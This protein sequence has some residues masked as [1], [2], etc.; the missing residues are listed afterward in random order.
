MRGS[1]ALTLRTELECVPLQP[2]SN[3]GDTFVLEQAGCHEYDHEIVGD[4]PKLKRVLEQVES[5]AP[6]DST[7]LILGETGTGKELVARRIHNRSARRQ[8]AFVI[9]NCAAI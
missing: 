4:S 8:Q 2:I 1:Y 6:T 3:C 5:V 7:V 9:V